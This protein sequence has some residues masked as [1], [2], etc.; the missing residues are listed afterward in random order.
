MKP[1]QDILKGLFFLI[2]NFASFLSFI[3]K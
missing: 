1:L 3:I 2:E